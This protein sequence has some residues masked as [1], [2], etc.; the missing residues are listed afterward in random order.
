[1][2]MRDEA[3]QYLL[4]GVDYMGQQV[5]LISDILVLVF[6]VFLMLISNLS[7]VFLQ[8][9]CVFCDDSNYMLHDIWYNLA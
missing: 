4:T 2:Q 1:M 5:V 3:M 9:V 8:H 7:L 6:T